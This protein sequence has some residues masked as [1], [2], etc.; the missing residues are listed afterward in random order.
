MEK[1]EAE[2][3]EFPYVSLPSH[4]ALALNPYRALA[5]PLVSL[6]VILMVSVFTGHASLPLL[7]VNV[8]PAVSTIVDEPRGLT[9]PR[10]FPAKSLVH[11]IVKNPVVV[12][13]RPET[14]IVH[15][16]CFVFASKNPFV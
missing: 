3:K 5:T 6:S 2:A 9:T 14:S 13:V 12:F 16:H 1:F 7:M 15:S 4:V 10:V 11:D 8:G